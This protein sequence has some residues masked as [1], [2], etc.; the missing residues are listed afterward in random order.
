MFAAGYVTAGGASR[1]TVSTTAYTTVAYAVCA[2]LLL[3]TCLAGGQRVV[4]YP[5]VTWVKLVALTIAAQLIGHSLIN[6]VLSST[7]ATVVSLAILFEV[8]GAAV[9]AA[10][11]LHQT[12]PV[13]AVPGLALLLAGLAIVVRFGGRGVPV[14]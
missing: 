9:L 8:P 14:E 12:V 13:A 5:G 3:L 4:G 2:F 6:R 7:S 10:I 11:F 1:R